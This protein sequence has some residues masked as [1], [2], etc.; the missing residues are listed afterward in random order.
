MQ[1]DKEQG[2]AGSSNE[3]PDAMSRSRGRLS[4]T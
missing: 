1:A 4:T 2:V 3:K